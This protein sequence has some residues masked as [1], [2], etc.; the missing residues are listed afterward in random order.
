MKQKFIQYGLLVL[1]LLIAAL[2]YLPV[3][4][5]NS[6]SGAISVNLPP[7][8]AGTG[9]VT[10]VVGGTDGAGLPVPSQTLTYTI[11]AIVGPQTCAGGQPVI[12]GLQGQNWNRKNGSWD[13]TTNLYEGQYMTVLGSHLGNP[14]GIS[15][16]PGSAFTGGNGSQSNFSLPYTP[17]NYTAT[18]TNGDA[19]CN[20]VN[21][22]VAINSTVAACGSDNGSSVYSLTATDPNLCSNSAPSFATQFTTTGQE[23]PGQNNWTWTCNGLYS[24]STAACGAMLKQD[25]QCVPWNGTYPNGTKFNFFVNGVPVGSYCVV[26]GD[27]FAGDAYATNYVQTSP[28]TQAQPWGGGWSWNCNGVNNGNP[29]SCSAGPPICAYFGNGSSCG[30]P[31]WYCAYG[32]SCQ[33][34][35]C[36]DGQ[37]QNGC[38]STCNGTQ[39]VIMGFGACSVGGTCGSTDSLTMAVSPSSPTIPQRRESIVYCNC[40]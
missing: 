20:S 34:G 33:A 27:R 19:T 4:A 11:N 37:I 40:D 5:S 21:T 23:L 31:G 15:G 36:V 2:F 13:Y 3:Y 24:N 25:G 22:G 1:S 12:S 38:G 29:V 7:G 17:G 35:T 30:A 26:Y 6:D 10:V 32:G 28:P 14:T 9:T 16:V 39:T 18:I 8:F